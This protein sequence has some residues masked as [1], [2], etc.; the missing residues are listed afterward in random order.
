MNKIVMI[1]IWLLVTMLSVPGWPSV[2]TTQEV[3]F[4]EE[5]CN[6]RKIENE[7]RLGDIALQSGVKLF[8]VE[9]WCIETAMFSNEGS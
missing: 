9:A 5:S 8:W 7:V 3:W 6:S 1:K 4:S 2:K